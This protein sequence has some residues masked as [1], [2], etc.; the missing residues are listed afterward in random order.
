MEALCLAR[1]FP[2]LL[3]CCICS[4]AY[5]N[6][7]RA[8]VICHG[9]G[10]TCCAECMNQTSRCPTCRITPH[11]RNLLAAQAIEAYLRPAPVIPYS[12]LELE[13]CFVGR[14]AD[15]FVYGGFWKGQPICYKSFNG[16][17]DQVRRSMLRECRILATLIHPS[18]VKLHGVVDSSCQVGLVVERLAGDLDGWLST[19]P[20]PGPLRVRLLL[21]ARDIAEAIAYAHGLGVRHRDLKPGNVLV[22]EGQHVKLA[23]FGIARVVEQAGIAANTITGRLSTPLYMAPELLVDRTNDA[24]ADAFSF[25]VL[26]WYMLEGHRTQEGR[27]FCGSL[28]PLTIID[29]YRQ[30]S[31]PPMSAALQATET[32]ALIQRCWS[33][34]PA[35]RPAFHAIAEEIAHLI[36]QEVL[37]ATS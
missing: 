14:G 19:Q 23:D 31:R 2:P 16:H 18:I 4:T 9:C 34:E 10:N 11:P 26:L 6:S 27:Q 15:A 37:S 17:P 29:L 33:A 13:G 8:P 24:H 12:E 20:A 3:D 32:G 7:G 1:A 28:N 36:E 21:L 5:D 22:T 35:E 25:G 30:G